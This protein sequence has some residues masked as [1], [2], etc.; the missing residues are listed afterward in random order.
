MNV[1]KYLS[2]FAAFGFILS[3]CDEIVTYNDGYDDG[4]VSQ[5][6]PQIDSVCLATAPDAAIQAGAMDQ[7][8]VLY[9]KNLGS[10]KSVRFNDCEADLKEI[11]VRNEKAGIRI[12]VKL[13]EVRN[14]KITYTTDKGTVE[15]PFVVD[16][17][18]MVITNFSNEFAA[19]GDTVTITG[20]YFELYNVTKDEGIVT[21]NGVEVTILE[22]SDTELSIE[23]PVGIDLENSKFL[24]SSELLDAPFE[25][26]FHVK[27]I[28]VYDFY[29]RDDNGGK[30]T[31]VLDG[32]GEGDPQPLI[33]G[34]K[35]FRIKDNPVAGGASWLSLCWVF[36]DVIEQGVPENNH[37][38]AN[39]GDYYLKF[40]VLTLKPIIEG[41]ISF[42]IGSAVTWAEKYFR[43]Q[44]VVGGVPFDTFQ[45]WQTVTIDMAQAYPDLTKLESGSRLENEMEVGMNFSSIDFIT[46]QTE[47]TPDFC[48]TNIR[49]VRK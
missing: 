38:L 39:P 33:P 30:K 42:S 14:D 45:K 34:H 11:F 10:L 23:V 19:T 28:A 31:V 32:S 13:P 8:I 2:L 16:V 47:E 15:Y 18:E 27:G 48:F 40:E 4:T 43:W 37:L 6:S 17:P 20:K 49:L 12:P 44:P 21:L 26:P 36:W 7:I 35:Y 29:N 3:A 1:I 9:G 24:V 25:I 5:G 41:E 46:G 22:S